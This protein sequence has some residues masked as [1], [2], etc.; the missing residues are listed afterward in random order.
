MLSRL[1]AQF[2]VSTLGFA[3]VQT[4]Q[5]GLQRGRDI[6]TRAAVLLG[7]AAASLAQDDEELAFTGAVLA[8]SCSV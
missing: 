5:I 8:P 1:L 7:I 4:C 2:P 6:V 3:G